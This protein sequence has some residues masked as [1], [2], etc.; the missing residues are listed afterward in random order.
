MSDVEL[1][2]FQAEPAEEGEDDLVG[3][4]PAVVAEAVVTGT[5][6]TTETILNQ[7]RRG[8]ID[9]DPSF[10]RREAWTDAR[11]SAFVESI[12]LGLPIPQ[13][14]L[15]EQQNRRGHF[16]VIDGKQRLL[17]LQKFAPPEGSGVEP[18]VLSGLAV[19]HDLLGKT[20]ADLQADPQ[21]A[22]DLAAFDNHTI[23][24]VVVR[25]WPNEDFLYL[26]FH[27][28]NTGS[29]P[30][31]P[32]ELRQA[33]HPGPFV[34]FVQGFSEGS[35]VLQSAL[36]STGPDFRMR[37]VEILIRFF[38]FS[39]F[40][41]DYRGN[42]KAFLDETCRA[43]NATWAESEAEVVALAAA[44]ENAIQTAQAVFGEF[45]FRRWNGETYERRFNR[46]VFDVM[47]YYFKDERIAEHA[48]ARPATVETAFK[49][50]S[51]VDPDFDAALRATT[52]TV[53]ATA[54]RLEAWGTA[55]REALGIE[56]D[57]A[58]LVDGVIRTA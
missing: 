57:V 4:T 31:S 35:D 55:L 38:G 32:Q 37:D 16:L 3:L 41:S 12:F 13:L 11:K 50:V 2:L 23:R 26:V 6:W 52:K 45:A 27:R 15:A 39:L 30:L 47:T 54:K 5:D 33:L 24:T 7:L 29:L 14:V 9:L 42:L 36:G 28:L 43:L 18:L 48:V 22:D 56:F 44:C 19:R 20:Y 51:V 8:T 53:A 21:F 46:A 40:L 25:N 17:A 49:E 10:Q 58:R 34:Q 1:E